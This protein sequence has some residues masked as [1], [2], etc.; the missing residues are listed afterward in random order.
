MSYFNGKL[1]R[2]DIPPKWVWWTNWSLFSSNALSEVCLD[3]KIRL[4]T[5]VCVIFFQAISGGKNVQTQQFVGFVSLQSW[6]S[7]FFPLT[8]FAIIVFS[9]WLGK[10]TRQNM[11][12]QFF[13]HT[14]WSCPSNA[15]KRFLL[16]KKIN[17]QK[18]TAWILRWLDFS[19]PDHDT[20]WKRLNGE[21]GAHWKENP[22]PRWKKNFLTVDM[23]ATSN[24][25]HLP[26]VHCFT[27][28]P[29]YW[30]G[31]LNW[32]ETTKVK[33]RIPRLTIGAK[34]L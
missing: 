13:H 33:E 19:K 18:Q 23:E 9:R 27:L 12:A 25:E 1:E 2:C 5:Q 3:K 8:F 17:R 14:H 26:F 31:K 28:R 11:H 30:I 4:I 10:K 21:V 16:G 7:I 34:I 15:H 24:V 6:T 22:P 29:S 20:S 32:N